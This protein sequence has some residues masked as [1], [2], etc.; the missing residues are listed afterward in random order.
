MR[1]G[2]RRTPFPE[3]FLVRI[4]DPGLPREGCAASVTFLEGMVVR[5]TGDGAVEELSIRKFI[6]DPVFQKIDPVLEI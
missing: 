2:F 1:E 6:Y 5:H 4:R 3:S